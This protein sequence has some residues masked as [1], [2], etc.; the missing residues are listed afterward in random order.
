MNDEPGFLAKST[1][2]KEPNRSRRDH[3]RR[4]DK[5]QYCGDAVVHWT[6]TIRDR[7]TGWLDA[8]FFYHFRELLTHSQFRFG[9]ACPIFCL[10]PE[11]LH[12]VWMGILETSDQKLAIRHLRTRLNESLSQI[13]F[14]LQ[15][16]PFDHV[17][18]KDERQHGA[19][20][21]TCEYLARNPER[22]ELVGVDEYAS[23]PYSGCLVPGYPEFKPFAP[24]FW[25]RFD[26]T[27]S[28]L[29]K[30]GVTQT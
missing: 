14:E 11:H 21:A 23:Y 27:V 3:L 17:L 1:T 7:R 18:R 12:L 19:I 24:D 28:Y 22:A 26:R 6:M 20:V 15:D 10:M 2:T 30:N 29:R 4:L 9:I 16:Q 13:G 8:R 25:T 5:A